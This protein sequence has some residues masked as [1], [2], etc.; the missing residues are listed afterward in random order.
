MRWKG[1]GALV[2]ACLLAG[3]SNHWRIL[4]MQEQFADEVGRRRIDDANRLEKELLELADDEYGPSSPE[5]L[6]VRG[7]IAETWGYWR[8]T[9]RALAL[10]TAMLSAVQSR[11]G[12]DNERT[13]P[14]R[15]T[16]AWILVFARRYDEAERMADA[17][18]RICHEVDMD[19]TR[20]AECRAFRSEALD[21]LYLSVGAYGKAIDEHLRMHATSLLRDDRSG[22]VAQLAVLGRW[23]ATGGHYPEAHWYFERCVEEAR[24]LY[25]RP[26]SVRTVWSSGDVRV[27]VVDGAHSFESQSPRSLEDL[28]RVE[29]Q[30]GNAEEAARLEA[31]RKE[32]WARGPDLEKQLVE[33]VRSTDAAWHDEAMTS[34]AANDLAWYY[35]GKGRTADA[36][37]AW[38]DAVN[39]MDLVVARYGRHRSG[40]SAWLHIDELLGLGAGCEEVGR[41]DDAAHA[42]ARASEIAEATLHPSHAWRFDA[43]AGQARAESRSAGAAQSEATWRRY[44]GMVEAERGDDHADYAFGLAGLADTL[45][46]QG[47]P[48]EAR[49]ARTRAETIRTETARRIAAVHDL[50]LPYALRSPPSPAN[51]PSP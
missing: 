19:S 9:D 29:R 16:I 23:H 2:I 11:Y 51:Y 28:I 6:R 45:T 44:L 15:Y 25:D 32:M 3:C 4:S 8:D 5:A 10:A 17:I 22:G 39:R 36:I 7:D 34:R 42:Y 37:R 47:R 26:P 33:A 35:H 41:F 50:P 49:S 18:A 43:V 12:S 24:P 20:R 14:A 48:K 31:R 40:G 27:S 30:T 13:V 38:E 46:A 1:L 21:S